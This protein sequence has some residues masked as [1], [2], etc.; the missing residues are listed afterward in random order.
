MQTVRKTEIAEGY[1][2]IFGYLGYIT[3]LVGGIILLPLL[4]LIFYPNEAGNAKYF[5]IPGICAIL[6]GYMLTFLIRGKTKGRLHQNQDAVIVVFSWIIAIVLSAIPWMLTGQYNFTQAVFETTSGYSTT[7][8]SVVAVDSAPHIF[9]MFRSIMLF[10]G[11]VGLVL[12]MMSVLSDTYGMRLYNAEGHSDQLSANLA[13]SARLIISIYA[14]YI[15]AGTLLY[16]LFGM[17]VFDALN[18]SIAALSTGGFS[19]HGANIG[20]YDSVPIEAITIVLMLLGCTNFLV[21]L[22]LI[23]GKFKAFFQH[24]EVKFMLFLTAFMMPFFM[25]LLMNGIAENLGDSARI[26]IFQIVT[27]LTTT[28]FQTVPGFQTWSPALLLLMIVLMLIG[29]GAGSTAG[30]MKLYRVYVAMKDVGWS[31]RD[32]LTHKRVIRSDSVMRFGKKETVDATYRKGVYT[33]IGL[34]LIIFLIGSF[35]YTCCGYSLQ[36]SMFEFASALGT[37]G[38]SIGVT[39]YGAAPIILWTASVGMFIGRLE[40]YIVFI[41]MA[42]IGKDIGNRFERN[43]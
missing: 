13:K 34:Y 8:L 26:A 38:L 42:R 29:G 21:H 16:V 24:C 10:F 15:L 6:V 28:G 9:L 17:S 14:G 33:F 31:M 43:G 18:N 25:V 1:R 19:T 3:V 39:S 23:Q 4:T 32:K 22:M 40:I 35:I 20:Y 30:G 36:D 5:A 27:A 7:G 37:V 12:V 2:L 41:A 11:G